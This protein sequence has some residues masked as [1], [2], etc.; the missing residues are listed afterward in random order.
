MCDVCGSSAPEAYVELR[1]NVGMVFT[2]ETV[3][4]TG[5][6]CGVCLGNAMWKHQLSNLVLGWWGLISFFVTGYYLVDNVVVFF[7]ARR[8]LAAIERKRR[9][10]PDD[11]PSDPLARLQ[12]FAHNVR[13][14]I[15]SGE[16]RDDIVEDLARVHRVPM[17]AAQ[18]FVDRIVAAGA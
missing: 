4:T 1:H 15:G 14:R 11:G 10:A 8:E 9:P 17:G 16:D 13:L 7:R 5:S 18:G 2:R 3:V 6:L 12:P